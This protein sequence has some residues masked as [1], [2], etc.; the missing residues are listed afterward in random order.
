VL[1]GVASNV[2]T[3]DH[4]D[5][6]GFRIRAENADRNLP[7]NEAVEKLKIEYQNGQVDRNLLT[8]T[9]Y[10]AKP[11]N[12]IAFTGPYLHN[13]SVRSLWELLHSPAQRAQTFRVGSKEF[14]PIWVGYEN[15]G[16]FVFDTRLRGNS[17]VGHTYGNE[18]DLY[19]KFYLL[20]YLKTL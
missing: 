16:D 7:A 8:P 18:L 10:R 1:L 2:I 20:Q 4:F 12:G 17:N 13:G 3:S 14:D 5:S 6:L 11:L 15:A 19:D 9:S